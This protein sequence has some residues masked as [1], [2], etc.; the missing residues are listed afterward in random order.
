MG[1]SLSLFKTQKDIDD[2]YFF[3]NIEP[4]VIPDK[5]I[6]PVDPLDPIKDQEYLNQ[7]AYMKISKNAYLDKD[8]SNAIAYHTI[9]GNKKM[10]KY[11]SL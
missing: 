6:K 1:G 5:P 3:D 4:E 2:T 9:C 10:L 8:N 7:I 11:A